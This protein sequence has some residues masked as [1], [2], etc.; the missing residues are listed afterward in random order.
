[1]TSLQQKLKNY[2]IILKSPNLNYKPIFGGCEARKALDAKGGP[3]A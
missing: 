2:Q 3:A 1:M